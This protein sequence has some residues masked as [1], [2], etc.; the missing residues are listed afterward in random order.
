MK[1][2]PHSRIGGVIRG[3]RMMSGISQADLAIHLGISVW[4]LNRVEH[5]KRAFNTDWLLKMPP[6]MSGIVRSHLIREISTARCPLVGLMEM[7]TAPV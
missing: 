5:G 6:A 4:C 2:G 7:M 1:I 3:A